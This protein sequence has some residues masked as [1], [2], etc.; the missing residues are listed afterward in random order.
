MSWV[1]SNTSPLTNLAAIGQFHL[2]EAL[3][4]Q[5]HIADAVWTELNACE[6]SWPGRDEVAEAAW[7]SR[8]RVENRFLVRALAL[9]LDRGE[10]ESIALAI[11]HGAGL[12]LLDERDG[13]HRAQGL[14]LKI[15]GVVGV[16]LL[17]KKRGLLKAIKPSLDGLREQAGFYLSNTVYK[18][19][20]RE[21]G[22]DA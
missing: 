13:R 14:G 15:M 20:L 21:G 1:V 3:F 6:R 12:I 19:A 18:C 8:Q 7:I 5:I 9:D 22:E 10:S 2:L 17:A 16:L 11:E 4:G